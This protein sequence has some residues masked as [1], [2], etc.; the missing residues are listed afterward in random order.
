VSAF[1]EVDVDVPSVDIDGGGGVDE[2][3]EEVT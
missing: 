2:I 3:T 1:L